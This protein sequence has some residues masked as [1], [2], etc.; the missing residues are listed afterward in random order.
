MLPLCHWKM[1]PIKFFC[2]GEAGGLLGAMRRRWTGGI[3]V[4]GHTFSLH[5]RLE[6]T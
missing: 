4:Q 1:L 2:E 6:V 5:R 3:C